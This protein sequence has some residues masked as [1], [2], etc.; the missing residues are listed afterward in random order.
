LSVVLIQGNFAAPGQPGNL[1]LIVRMA[2][3]FAGEFL[4]SYHRTFDG[5][6]QGPFHL[7]K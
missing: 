2:G 5:A 3:V 4:A 1:E 6:W 7:G